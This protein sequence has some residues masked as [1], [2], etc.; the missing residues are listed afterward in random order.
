MKTENFKP[1]EF[2]Y[3][4]DTPVKALYII[5]QGTVQF[6][7]SNS[8]GDVEITG[9]KFAGEYFGEKSLTSDK[10]YDYSAKASKLLF[11]NS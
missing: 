8:D 9:E 2:I 10:N 3:T 11:K 4:E 6:S 7:H 1:D 5:Q